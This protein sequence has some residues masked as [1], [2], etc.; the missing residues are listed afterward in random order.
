MQSKFQAASDAERLARE[1]CLNMRSK[2]SS[3]ETQLST[4]THQSEMV[5]MEVEQQKAEKI[6]L[7]QELKR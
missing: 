4:V 3:L 5:K 6:I 2:V 7:E 1:E